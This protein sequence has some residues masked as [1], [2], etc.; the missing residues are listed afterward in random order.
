MP[1]NLP[2]ITR[3]ALALSAAFA[4]AL[5]WAP[6]S[7]RADLPEVTSMV[8][9]GDSYSDDGFADGAGFIRSTETTTWVEQMAKELGLPLMNHAWSGAMSDQ[10]NCNHP[11][12]VDWSG[13][14]WQ[15]DQY[16]ADLPKGADISKVLFVIMVGSND[17]WGGGTD[18][19]ATAGNIVGAV[20]R[21]ADKG[22][23]HL[24]YR[25]T[26]AVLLSP[27]YLAGD[28]MSYA[29]PWTKLV[30]ESNAATRELLA[31]GLA[32]YPDLKIY[33][34][35]TDGLF[36]KVKSG[37]KGFQFKNLTTA[38][39]GTYTFPDPAVHLWYD[40]WHPMGRLHS[41]M[42]AEALETLKGAK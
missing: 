2:A 35:E 19:K 27:G 36:E 18:G 31:G 29:E 22:A 1:K 17:A 39:L 20:K 10:R 24:L 37:A 12:G 34:Q 15:V 9:F 33:Y 30:N 26:S 13:L 5:C 42:A 38:W 32:G 41:M 4:L 40:E 8:V 3:A 11:E 25:E 23:K 7:A 14:Q 6:A 21:L 16:L 28:Y